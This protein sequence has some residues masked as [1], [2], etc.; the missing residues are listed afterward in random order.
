[1]SSI[2][3]ITDTDASL[4]AVVAEKYGIRQV[5]INVL[6]GDEELETGVDIDD[7]QLFAR[8]NREG[9]LPT[10][11]A[12]SPGQFAKAYQAAFA[13]GADS[14]IC[15]CVSGEVSATMGAAVNAKDLLPGRDIEV[16]DTRSLTMAQGF[17]VLEAA[18]AAASGAGKEEII[19]RAMDV[20]QRTHLYGALATLKYLRMSGRVG[21]LTAGMASM[22]NIKPILTIQ[23]GKLDMLE[24]IR[25]RKRAWARTIE[26]AQETANGR[27]IEQMAVV[28]VD[29]PDD[30]R[31]F[32]QQLR[33]GLT[34]PSE[35]M[36]TELTAGLSVHSGAG[37][38]GVVFVLA[39]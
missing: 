28:H 33:A 32:E 12:P 14:I 7:A 4:P 11:S 6:F 37:F 13:N 38:V 39:K 18:K 20:G 2:A 15:F 30:A 21:H 25:T 35:I 31:E 8:I 36:M 19:A 17:M 23:E 10:T 16:V 26:L 22:L 1:M 9:R 5:P 27:A 3:I 24:R 34:C 29:C